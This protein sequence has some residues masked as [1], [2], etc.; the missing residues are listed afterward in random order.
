[1]TVVSQSYAETEFQRAITDQPQTWD[2]LVRFIAA[3]DGKE[4]I[5]EPVDAGR[6]GKCTLMSPERSG[7]RH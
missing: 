2:R 3:E 1:M 4:Y 7:K 5:G 6:D